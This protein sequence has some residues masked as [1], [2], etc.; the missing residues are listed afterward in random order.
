MSKSSERGAWVRGTDRR[1]MDF[2]VP[3][4]GVLIWNWMT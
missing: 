3:F 4:H 2:W 1:E